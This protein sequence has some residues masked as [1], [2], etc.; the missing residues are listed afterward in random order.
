MG[1][2]TRVGEQIPVTVSHYP[3]WFRINEAPSDRK[4]KM[5]FNDTLGQ[6]EMSTIDVLLKKFQ[7]KAETLF[8]GTK[9]TYEKATI[10]R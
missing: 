9:A 3:L 1:I 4:D 2:I 10:T 7:E 6:S 5:E 8:P